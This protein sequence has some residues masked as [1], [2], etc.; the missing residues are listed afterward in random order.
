MTYPDTERW[1]DQE[2]DRAE[3]AHNHELLSDEE[4]KPGPIWAQENSWSA[5]AGPDTPYQE[6]ESS[7]AYPELGGTYYDPEPYEREAGS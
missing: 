4:P 3:E 7:G 2:R 1:N 6:W 5:P